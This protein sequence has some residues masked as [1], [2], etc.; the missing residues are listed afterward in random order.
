[1]K[2][3]TA[4]LLTLS[5]VASVAGCG[6]DTSNTDDSASKTDQEIYEEYFGVDTEEAEEAENPTQFTAEEIWQ[7]ILDY[8][9]EFGSIWFYYNK[10][11]V[12]EDA[13]TSTRIGEYLQF[14]SKFAWGPSVEM[15]DRQAI[16]QLLD[17]SF[18]DED[19]PMSDCLLMILDACGIETDASKWVYLPDDADGTELTLTLQD[20]Y[21]DALM[22]ELIDA[23]P[24]DEITST[25]ATLYVSY[26]DGRFV[27]TYIYYYVY[28][29]GTHYTQGE[30]QFLMYMR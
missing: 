20:D 8:T 5:L 1:M 24:F 28:Q 22:Q 4:L 19:L 17:Y 25:S 18:P 16:Y 15:E 6:T 2:K 11:A 23:F 3:L 12:D 27:P 9:D 7:G 30:V 21:T 10:Q 26:E 13:N 29:D 14:G